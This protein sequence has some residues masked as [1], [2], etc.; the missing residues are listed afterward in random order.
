VGP[1]L[2]S[3]ADE[4][5]GLVHVPLVVMGHSHK[6]V[7]TILADGTTRYVNLGSWLSA[8]RPEVAAQRGLPHLV[9]RGS[10]AELLRWHPPV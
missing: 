9:V 4:L 2:R 10:A 5:A 6:A 3:A 8:A 1:K 7:D